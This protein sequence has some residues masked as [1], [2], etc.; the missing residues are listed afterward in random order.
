MKK[1]FLLWTVAALLLLFSTSLC[2]VL[3]D[4][5][6]LRAWRNFKETNSGNWSIR[7]N[8]KTGT[9]AS[10]CF[11]KTKPY[12]GNP[13]YAARTFLKENVALTKI[14]SDTSNLRL[15]RIMSHHNISDVTFQETY[16]GI[17]TM[18]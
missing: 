15:S 5:V 10:I 6:Q 4:S 17:Q 14:N 7:W 11:G 8:R 12:S 18:N 3:P 9:P 16:N 13:E 1:R 2:Q